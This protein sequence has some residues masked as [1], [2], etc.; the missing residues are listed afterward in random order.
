[1]KHISALSTAVLFGLAA[2]GGSDSGS[3]ASSAAS[4]PA[5]SAPAAA[6]P[7]TGALQTPDWYQ[8]DNAA[9]T[10]TLAITA[11]ATNKGNYWNY[12]GYT[13]GE[14]T[15]VVPVGYTVTINYTNSDP[16]MAHS[17]GVDARTSGFP[18]AFPADYQPVFEGAI[19]ENPMDM[20]NAT[21]TGESETVTFVASE[22][23]NYSLACYVPGHAV[24]GMWIGFEVSASGDAGV[25]M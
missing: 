13:N 16:N 4:A 8:V 1:M 7:A 11:G 22:A 2:C 23:G 25:R 19:S 3:A 5:A 20:A 10:V 9:R 21:L 6:A 14:V 24:V 17:I 18:A 15:V 12:N